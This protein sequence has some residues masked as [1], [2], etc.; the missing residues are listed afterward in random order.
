M[1]ISGNSST[2]SQ[3]RFNNRTPE[4]LLFLCTIVF[5]APSLT[6]PRWTG[7]NK[8]GELALALVI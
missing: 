2:W 4:A 7:E 6:L 5:F 1:V 3:G 8:R